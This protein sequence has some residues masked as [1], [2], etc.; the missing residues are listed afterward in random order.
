MRDGNLVTV[1]KY[2]GEDTLRLL[3]RIPLMGVILAVLQ[4]FFGRR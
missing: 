3:E 2:E 4:F 1:I